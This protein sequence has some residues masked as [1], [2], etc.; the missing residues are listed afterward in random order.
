MFAIVESRY[1]AELDN[2]WLREELYTL[3]HDG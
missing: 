2:I 3:L 1:S